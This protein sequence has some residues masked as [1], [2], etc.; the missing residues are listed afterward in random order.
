MYTCKCHSYSKWENIPIYHEFRS[1]ITGYV[2]KVSLS[3]FLQV[4][5]LNFGG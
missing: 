1:E 2:I 5:L 4:R 3:C